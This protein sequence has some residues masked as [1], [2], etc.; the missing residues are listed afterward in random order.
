MFEVESSKPSTPFRMT[1]CENGGNVVIKEQLWA[2]L[3]F[4]H[5]FKRGDKGNLLGNEAF[6]SF[7]RSEVLTLMFMKILLFWD[8]TPYMT[9]S[10]LGKIEHSTEIVLDRSNQFSSQCFA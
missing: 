6:D 9:E 1:Q 4:A 2:N 5:H 3:C 7:S 10:Y 8:M